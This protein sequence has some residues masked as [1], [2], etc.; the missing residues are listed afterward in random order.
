[1][2]DQNLTE[3]PMFINLESHFI[4]ACAAAL[5]SWHWKDPAFQPKWL[6]PANLPLHP[7][8]FCC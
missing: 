7:Y 2:I 1:M 3:L 6:L 8:D 5:G 4:D